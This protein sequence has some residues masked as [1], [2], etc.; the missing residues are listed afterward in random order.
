MTASYRPAV[1]AGRDSFGN[2]LRAE[3]TKLRSVRRWVLGL[4]AMILLTIGFSLFMTAGSGSDLNEN[5]ELLGPVGPDGDRVKDE[6]HFVHQPLTGDGSITARVGTFTGGRGGP[7][8]HEWARAG[9][10]IRESATPGSPY[11][12]VMVSHGHGVRFQANYTT[13][14]AGGAGTA[15]RWLRLD[16]AGTTITGYESTDGTTWREV[17]AFDLA[18]LPSTVQVGLFVASPNRLEL[19]RF[20]GGSSSGERP[21]ESLATFDNVRLGA[22]PPP[23]P[24]RTHDTSTGFAG[25]MLFTETEGVLTVSGSGDIGP[26]VPDEDVAQMGLIGIL[27][28]QMVVAAIGVL[29][30][31]SEYKRGMIRTTLAATPRR[32]RVLAAKALVFGAATFVVGLVASVTTFFAAQPVLRA[33]GFGPPAYPTPSL[34]DWPVLRAVVG[35]AVFLALVGLL[36]LGLG[37]ILRRSAGAITAV[38]LAFVPVI[39]VADALPLTAAQWLMRTA[40]PAGLAILQTLPVDHDTSN[41]AWNMAPPLVGLGV[42]AGWTAAA[43]AVGYWQLRRRDA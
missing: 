30:I 6:R 2:L 39:L 28:G 20:V 29:F 19:E 22:A 11:A 9:L 38:V 7:P 15:P 25:D 42:L 1:P 16:R 8:E 5:P 32:G 24:W 40:P 18:G 37:T 21:T 17:G 14:L 26:N 23:A 12:A 41:E 34:A 3:W 10:M 31:T 13:D 33:S 35:A 36:G 43:L 4:L 27:V